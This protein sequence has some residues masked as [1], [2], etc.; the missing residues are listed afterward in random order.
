MGGGYRYYLIGLFWFR[1]DYECILLLGAGNRRG[2]FIMDVWSPL[3]QSGLDS[4]F[5]SGLTVASLKKKWEKKVERVSE[6]IRQELLRQA[7]AW[8]W[9][10][11]WCLHRIDVPE[12]DRDGF[13]S[14][15]LRTPPPADEL[16]VI[17]F[18]ADSLFTRPHLIQM[19]APAEG[20]GHL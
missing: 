8:C 1:L 18:T 15:L 9:C 4:S 12:G 10:W 7:G 14:C 11:C 3:K 16:I 13:T 5:N 2:S 20:G 19:T 6:T 17:R